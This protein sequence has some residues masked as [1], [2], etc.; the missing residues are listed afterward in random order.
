[1]KKI[2][3]IL[4]LLFSCNIE[5]KKIVIGVDEFFPP[6]TFRENNEL[7]GIDVDLAKEVFKKLGYEIEFKPVVWE[8]IIEELTNKNIDIIWS[9]LSVTEERKA[10]IDFSIP[11]IETRQVIVTRYNS[12]IETK[13]DLVSKIIGVQKGSTGEHSLKKDSV[14][15]KKLKKITEYDTVEKEIKDLEDGKIDAIVVDEIAAKYFLAG[16]AGNFKILNEHFGYEIFAV[17]L[18]KEDKLLKEKIDKA[19]TTIMKNGTEEKIFK[20]WL[21]ENRILADYLKRIK[22]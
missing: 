19:L 22:N 1:M 15:V 16:K 14:L 8:K 9:G 6:M 10:V 20:K 12:T 17:G 7:K 4:L 2:F 11:Y 18:R 5:K 21:G 3:F 13:E